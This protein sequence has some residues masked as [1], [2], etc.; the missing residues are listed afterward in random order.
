MKLEPFQFQ[1]D[2]MEDMMSR[3]HNGEKRL[4]VVMTDGLGKKTTSLFLAR[5]LCL[6]EQTNI[7]MVFRFRNDLS[8]VKS[9]AEE[10]GGLMA[11]YYSVNEFLN[12]DTNYRYVFLYDLSVSDRKQI[13]DS[14]LIENSVSISFSSIGQEIVKKKDNPKTNTLLFEYSEKATPVICVYVTRDVLD[15]RDA[16]YAGEAECSYVNEVNAGLESWLQ[17]RKN[18][19]INER[20]EIERQATEIER[21]KGLLQTDERDKKINDLE[22]REA[23]YQEQMK[24]KDAE[25]DLLKQ[26]IIYMQNLLTSFGI[27]KETLEESFAY[28][29]TIRDSLKND[30]ESDDEAS[31]EQAQKHLQDAIAESISS[32]LKKSV[33]KTDMNYYEEGLI[34]N[35]TE[36]VWNRLD[37]NSKTYLITAKSTYEVMIKMENADNY[38]YSGVCLLVTKALEVEVAK[39]FFY[40]YKDYLTQEFPSVLDWPYCLRQWDHGRITDKVIDDEEFTLGSVV[41]VIG[42]YRI[43]DEDGHIK[44][45]GIKNDKE[46][47]MFL[48][49]AQKRLYKTS[50]KNKVL[51]EIKRDYQFIEN[52]RLKYRN[53]AAHRDGLTKV[54]AQTCLQYVIEIQCMLKKMLGSMKI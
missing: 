31:K 43:Y 44:Q 51:E 24:T 40:S 6:E 23:N 9:A 30:F 10:L 19:A 48:K 21:L 39:R 25:I 5:K 46:Y 53:P 29:Q 7:A 33:Y 50:D 27:D 22:M 28:I 18:Q 1:Y 20:A 45:F 11:D 41:P 49:Y 8:V 3:V 32:T 15:I 2:F 36:D 35:L 54:S 37:D 42:R 4:S 38:D 34:G 52:V 26:M 47:E 13:N 16:K 14:S 17:D 12:S